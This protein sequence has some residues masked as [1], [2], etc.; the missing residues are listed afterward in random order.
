[1]NKAVLKIYFRLPLFFCIILIIKM[2]YLFVGGCARSGTSSLTR[3]LNSH[4]KILV[5]IERY[6]KLCHKHN[7]S[8]NKGHFLKKRFFQVE[9]GD[10][11]YSDFSEVHKRSKWLYRKYESLEYIGLKYTSIHNIMDE[12]NSTFGN[13]VIIYIYRDI[14]DVAESWNQRTI[15]GNNWPKTKNYIEAVEEWNYSLKTIKSYIENKQEIICVNY[16]DVFY[17]NKSLKKLFAELNLNVHFGVFFKIILAR[18]RALILKR[19]RSVLSQKDYS[20]VL[21]NASFELY[22]HFNDNFNI[23]R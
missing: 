1:M 15:K 3:L 17:S 4:K 12:L 7:Y 10:T 21:K 6:N 5:G 22:E 16:N 11:F 18:I 20:Y 19:K 8:L 14:F 2:K 23:L 9:K 13:P